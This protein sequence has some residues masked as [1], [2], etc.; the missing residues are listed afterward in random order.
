MS[1]H[2]KLHEDTTIIVQKQKQFGR[3]DYQPC[4]KLAQQVVE[5]FKQKGFTAADL[6]FLQGMGYCVLVAEPAGVT[7]TEFTP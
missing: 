1:E 6:K 5:G 4:N 3:I 7:H 2:P